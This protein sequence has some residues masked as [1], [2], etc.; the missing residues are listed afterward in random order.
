MKH[1]NATATPHYRQGVT[2][3]VLLTV[4]LAGLI[5]YKIRP[6]LRNIGVA[7]ATGS[8]TLRPY[9][10]Q[11]ANQSSLQLVGKESFAY[12]RIIWPALLFG[13]LIAAAA[14]IAISHEWVARL[15]ETVG[16]RGAISGAAAGAPLMLCSCC[17]APVF[18]GLYE[19][20]HRLDAPLALM[21]AAPSLNP[22]A[23]ILTFML[24]PLPIAA[25]RVAMTLIALAGIAVVGTRMTVSPVLKL[26]EDEFASKRQ[27]L[28]FSF[29][30]AMVHV[31]VRTV[32]LILA[33]IAVGIFLFNQAPGS[34][35][36]IHS[37][38]P[39]LAAL[40][41]GAALLLPVPTLFEIP[42]GYS[43]FVAG[44]PAGIVTAVLFAG[45]VVNLPSLLV[46]GRAAGAR[47]ATTLALFLWLVAVAVGFAIP[48]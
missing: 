18:E 14:R 23:L 25:G 16:W 35:L 7:R 36:L 44:I 6:A 45:P 33:G 12:L 24:F 32:P 21:L 41:V 48:R 3:L 10:A 13:T 4:L 39:F 34:A 30:V 43:L 19:R 11:P 15:V 2:S 22:A 9:L 27:P 17:A 1:A 26:R 5:G 42:L 31:A 20:T 38:S 47:V 37:N 40:V 46:V 8:L 29:A 28:L